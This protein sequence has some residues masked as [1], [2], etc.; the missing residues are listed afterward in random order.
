MPSA[1]DSPQVIEEYLQ[2][3]REQGNILGPFAPYLIPAVHINRFGVIPKKHQ[4]GKWCLI[5]DL[6]FPEG[7]SVNDAIDPNLCS[8]KYITVDQVAKKAVAL[9]KGSLM[10]KIDIKSAYRLIPVAPKDRLYLGMKWEGKVYIDGMLPFGL[11]SAP[12]IFSAVADALEW[13]VAREGVDIIYHYLDDFTVLG[14]SSSEECGIPPK[15][16]VCMQG[17]GNSAGSRETSWPKHLH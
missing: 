15:T 14:P 11:R 4:P 12:K 7:K 1:R 3:E 13:C 10:A 2:K 16:K 9:G 5:T 6:S 17:P 8:F